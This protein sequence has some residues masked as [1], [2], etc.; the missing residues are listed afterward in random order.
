MT[1]LSV[2][3][4]AVVE[5]DLFAERVRLH[6]QDKGLRRIH[7]LEAGCGRGAGLPLP[8]G[9]DRHVTGIDL[10]T[11]ALRERTASRTDLDTFHLGD[12]RNAP[13]P[14]RVY[15][16]VH[17]D[18][19]IE[20]IANA[21]LVLDRMIAALKPGGLLL[22]RF[23]DR[24]SAYGL[25]RRT[26]PRRVRRMLGEDVRDAQPDVFEP[27]T[28]LE[29]MRNWCLQRGLVIAEAHTEPAPR[30]GGVAA[31]AR[32]LAGVS[33]GRI[34]ADHGRIVL[35]VRKPESRFARII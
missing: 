18:S 6:A 31:L 9:L 30:S 29:G 28:S 25:I 13:L 32:L 5:D 10:D 17:A 26:L 33:G 14:P 20:H 2:R 4:R 23:T 15:D 34:S 1:E 8:D 22:V 11:P 35:V 3:D 12:L 24:D 27:I 16:V 21:E 19:L 7:I